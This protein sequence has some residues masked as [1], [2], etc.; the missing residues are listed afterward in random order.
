MP[1]P[2]PYTPTTDF[3]QQEAN[4]AAGRS[5]VNTAALDAEFAAIE[6]T[7]D[8]TCANLQLIQR[9]DGRLGDVT[10]EVRCLSPDTLNLM[11]GFKLTGLWTASTDYAVNDICSNAEYTYVCN[12]AHT[13]GLTFDSSYWVQFGFTSG[14]DA[15]QAAAEAQA[16]AIAAASSETNANSY[17]NSAASSA[18]S[19]SSSASSASASAA[20]ATTQASNASVYATSASNSAAAAAASAAIGITDSSVDTLTNKTMSADTN[21]IEARSAP[22]ATHFSH[23]NKIINGDFRVNQRSYVSAAAVGSVLYGHDRW[24]MAASGD[25]YTFSTTANKTTV[26]IPAGKVLQQV[27]EGLNLQTG[28]YTLSW[29]GTAQGKIGAGAYA[30]SGVTGAITGGTDT[31]I[32]FGPGTVANVQLEP[33]SKATPFEFRS[34]GEDLSLCRRYL[35]AFR[36][37]KLC[38]MGKAKDAFNTLAVISLPVA[39]RVAPTGVTISN[40]AHFAVD[41]PAASTSTA[42][43]GISLVNA[44]VDTI[45]VQMTNVANN[46][47]ASGGAIQFFSNSAS[48]YIL[49]TGCE[50]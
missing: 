49:F 31:T 48:A 18:A 37:D 6:T 43:S 29:E 4:N 40:V 11:G 41:N 44:N 16:S 34:Y 21:V 45:S 42:I 2:T 3:S 23:R 7:L 47:N 35:P 25:T 27:V 12:A 28:T 46:G 10:V 5:T 13:S 15:A 14:A 50:L 26:T 17:K 38:W 30:A 1:Q 22:S 36:G 39:A 24:K 32:E 20:T 8:Q 9:D 33:G 19:A